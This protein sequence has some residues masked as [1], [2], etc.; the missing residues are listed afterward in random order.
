MA[1]LNAAFW[2]G[3]ARPNNLSTMRKARYAYSAVDLSLCGAVKAAGRKGL[4]MCRGTQF[5]SV[6]REVPL[7]EVFAKTAPRNARFFSLLPYY[8][9]KISEILPLNFDSLDI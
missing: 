3:G 5:Q 2:T 8:N 1:R 7:S 9:W 6:G 4:L